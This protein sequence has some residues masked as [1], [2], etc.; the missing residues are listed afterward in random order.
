MKT[1]V[2]AGMSPQQLAALSG[3]VAA[4]NS[5]TPAEAARIAQARVDQ[6][7]AQRDAEMDKDRR[8]QLDLLNLQNDVNKAAL[9][10]QSQLGVGVAQA[11]RQAPLARQCA[12]GH[13]AGPNDK[14]CAQCGAA[15]QP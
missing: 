15:L 1:Q 9:S 11:S 7:R 3:V 6:E 8:H 4:T 10:T 5:V 2:H 14:F 13:T 12:N